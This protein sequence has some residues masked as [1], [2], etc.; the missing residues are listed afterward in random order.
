LAGAFYAI[1]PRELRSARA[2]VIR[3]RTRGWA[4]APDTAVDIDTPTDLTVARAIAAAA[5]IR[6]PVPVARHVVGVGA[7]F[8]IAEAGVN[9]DGD[10]SVAHRLVDAAADAGADAVKFQTFD[11]ERL[12]AADAPLAAYQAAA[13]ERATQREMLARLALPDEAWA[14]LQAHAAERKIVFLSSPFDEASADLLDRLDVPAFKVGSGEL[15]NLPFLE[16]LARI[17]RP[18]LVSTGMSSMPEVDAALGAVRRAGDPPVAL[19]HCVSAYPADAT[20][21]N[22]AAIATMRSAFR[23]PVGWSDHSSGTTL[24]VAA[25]AMGAD[26]IEKHLTL[27]RTRSGPDHGASLEP[28]AFGAMARAIRETEAARGIGEKVPTSAERDVARVARRGLYWASDVPAGTIVTATHVTSLRPA[29]DISPAMLDTVM[30]RRVRV[31]VRAGTPV[32]LEDLADP[33]ENDG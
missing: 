30:G 13:G 18:M 20:D 17:G 21:A 33:S 28:D 9:H 12:A 8:L 23:V 11:P 2:F 27:D 16:H 31:E 6:R 3:D 5:P 22:L 1:A 29:T 7:A 19:F 14:A 24:P 10:V 4:I 15:T 25:V 32:K 26:L